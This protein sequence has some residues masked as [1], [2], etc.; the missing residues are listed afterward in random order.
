VNIETPLFTTPD[1]SGYGL[2][3]NSAIEK[4]NN[5]LYAYT[6]EN[7]NTTQIQLYSLIA[8]DDAAI[9]KYINALIRSSKASGMNAQKTIKKIGTTTRQIVM[10]TSDD[11]VWYE[12]IQTHSTNKTYMDFVIAVDKDDIQSDFLNMQSFVESIILKNSYAK[13]QV[14]NLPGIS[15]SS[16]RG[17]SIV[18]WIG[19]NGLNISVLPASA[20]FSIDLSAYP[21]TP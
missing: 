21:A 17:V 9:Q 18:K 11:I 8:T 16:K 12:Y 5:N 14:L 1:F 6:L 2:S 3:L 15:L 19:D 20:N 10:S 13:P 4:K 7:G